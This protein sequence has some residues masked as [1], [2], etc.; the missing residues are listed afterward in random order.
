MNLRIAAVAA[1]AFACFAASQ[2]FAQ[3]SG[4][5]LGIYAYRSPSGL[6]VT[7]TIPG[8]SAQGRLFRNDVLL[9]VTAGGPIYSVRSHHQIEFAKDQI[10]PFTPAAL[11]IWRPHVGRVY[12]WVEFTPIGGIHAYSEGQPVK[13]K[14][15]IMTEQEKP[16][17][18]R[19]FQKA[20]QGGMV[21]GPAP[22]PQ[23]F[24]QPQPQPN[25]HDPSSLFN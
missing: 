21:P 12:L 6:R 11:E 10:G 20:E 3:E 15:K 22:Q 2:S 7:G 24:P 19:L 17:A 5:L 18:A 4:L 23:P 8:Y 14:A 16:G 13:M 1:L 25:P 9:R